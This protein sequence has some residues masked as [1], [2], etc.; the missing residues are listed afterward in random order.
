MRDNRELAEDVRLEYSSAKK[1]N[2]MLGRIKAVDK[3]LSFAG[4]KRKK[5]KDMMDRIYLNMATPKFDPPEYK[6]NA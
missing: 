4:M 3:Q 1:E 6:D 2:A 5:K